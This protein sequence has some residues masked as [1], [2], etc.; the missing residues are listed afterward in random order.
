MELLITWD[1]GGTHADVQVA[2]RDGIVPRGAH[3]LH[4]DEEYYGIPYSAWRARIG[5]TVDVPALQSG[6]NSRVEGT[7]FSVATHSPAAERAPEDRPYVVCPPRVTHW[8]APA[9]KPRHWSEEPELAGAPASA[10]Y[11]YHTGEKWISCTREQLIKRCIKFPTTPLVW[12]A[13]S[14]AV[15]PE[16][17]S[18]LVDEL[19]RHGMR[20]TALTLKL[21]VAGLAVTLAAFAFWIPG[22]G[23]RSVLVLLP[24][25]LAVG[26]VQAAF[27][28]RELRRMGAE[29]FPAARAWSR[30][31]AWMKAQPAHYTKSLLALLVVVG[32]AQMLA[33]RASGVALAG[34]VKPAVWNGEV[35][36]LLTGTLLHGN[37]THLWMNGAGL[38]AVGPLVE[39][40]SRRDHV[41]LVFLLSAL[42]GSVASVL[43]YPDATSVGASG[44]L[45]GFTGF[46]LVLGYR[47]R[48][49]LPQGFAG[50][51]VLVI[52]ATAV[53]GLVGF[54]LID[55]AAHLG[56]LVGGWV[57]GRV[58][59][60]RGMIDP[61]DSRAT[62]TLGRVSAGVLLAGAA[63]C[64][65]AMHGGY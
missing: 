48:D 38:L 28:R 25:F 58:L 46:L 63:W 18:F 6:F 49:K 29:A 11:G 53:L 51:I 23:F 30:H 39:V 65:L 12:T 55:N 41:P 61:G 24:A 7:A 36:R 40:H 27:R 15:P 10:E 8:P 52:A 14:A 9:P 37:F 50:A 21:C 54:S 16:R 42:A 17:V 45:M 62:R 57:L 20:R 43:L 26:A 2:P 3:R 32:I 19:T 64:V 1:D 5:R 35:W 34:L 13:G 59:E 4:P 22:W 60:R 31:A 33:G 47:R 56:G 44:G